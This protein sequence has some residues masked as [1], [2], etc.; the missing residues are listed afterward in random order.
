MQV[1]V[2]LIGTREFLLKL[3]CEQKRGGFARLMEAINVLGLQVVDANITTFNGN[4][5]NIFRVEV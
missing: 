5:L 1:E 4:V 3:L 2:K